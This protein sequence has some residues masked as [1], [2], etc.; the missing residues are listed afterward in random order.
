MIDHPSDI[1]FYEAASR[2]YLN[3]HENK[4]TPRTCN[5]CGTEFDSGKQL[6][7]HLNTYTSHQ[8][9]R[10]E[11]WF[12]LKCKCGEIT[13]PNTHWLNRKL[14][15]NCCRTETMLAYRVHVTPYY[16]KE[17]EYIVEL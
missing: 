5:V 9:N 8:A 11:M 1:P 2:R 15:C 7:K 13:D 6:F 3:S 14:S 10:H 12:E 4:Q 17:L 16:R